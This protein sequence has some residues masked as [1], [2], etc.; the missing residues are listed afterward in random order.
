MA[1][2]DSGRMKMQ[3]FLLLVSC[4]LF[5]GEAQIGCSRVPTNAQAAAHSKLLAIHGMEFLVPERE[6]LVFPSN[7]NDRG[8]LSKRATNVVNFSLCLELP[9]FRLRPDQAARR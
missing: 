5:C 4:V 2:G 1:I 8:P 9:Q 3:R 6:A 7:V